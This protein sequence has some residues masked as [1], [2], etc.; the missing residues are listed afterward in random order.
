MTGYFDQDSEK[1][2]RVTARYGCA[3][4]GPYGTVCTEDAGHRYSHYDAQDDSSW[5]DDWREHGPK[6]DG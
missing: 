4:P 1:I 6:D 3:E 2:A 5:Q